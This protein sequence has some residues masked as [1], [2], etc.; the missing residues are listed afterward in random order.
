VGSWKRTRKEDT[1]GDE[2]DAET[3]RMIARRE[4]ET[5]EKRVTY[6]LHVVVFVHTNNGVSQEPTNGLHLPKVGIVVFFFCRELCF[7]VQCKWF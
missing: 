5:L 3:R 6:K 1:I 2:Q 7:F 4:D